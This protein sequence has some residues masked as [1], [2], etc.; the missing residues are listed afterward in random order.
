M[1]PLVVAL[2]LVAACTRDLPDLG[3]TY[4]PLQTATPTTSPGKET[5]SSTRAVF[6]HVSADE[7]VERQEVRVREAWLESPDTLVLSADTCNENPEVSALQE[8]DEEVQVLMRADAFPFRQS[9]P[10]CVE[11]ITVQLQAPLGDRVV[12]DQHTGRAVSVTQLE[13]RRR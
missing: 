4:A 13:Q 6:G 3:P 9:Y 11:A 1:T 10:D 8:T 5:E 7:N 2:L 12:V